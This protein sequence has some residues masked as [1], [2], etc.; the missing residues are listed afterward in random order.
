MRTLY[1]RAQPSI[2]GYG[3]LHG[4]HL[5]D[6]LRASSDDFLLGY[7]V[8]D[9]P[10][11]TRYQGDLEN[12]LIPR[13]LV[14]QLAPDLIIVE[15][16]LFGPI[17]GFQSKLAADIIA[18]IDVEPV[19]VIAGTPKDQLM[20]YRDDYQGIWEFLGARAVYERDWPVYG[21]QRSPYDSH[22]SALLLCK[23]SEMYTS[24]WLLPVFDEIETVGVDGPVVI[25]PNTDG[26]ATSGNNTGTLAG[27]LWVDMSDNF[28]WGSVDVRREAT[29]C[30]LTGEVEGDRML[31]WVPENTRWLTQLC[32][33]L[34]DSRRNE[35]ARI[36]SHLRSPHTVFLAHRSIDKPRVRNIAR[37]LRGCGIAAWLDEDEI[38]LGDS[39]SSAISSALERASCFVLCWSEHCVGAPWV[40]RELHTSV[41]ALIEGRMPIIVIRLD[42]TPVPR[43]ISDLRRL[44]AMDLQPQEIASSLAD[45]LRTLKSRPNG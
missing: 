38:E 24:Q 4:R 27:D 45:A 2:F 17:Q 21:V 13:D 28:T 43:I 31:E 41:H 5:C 20:R 30:W 33:F 22:L 15:A 44:D 29:V 26:V 36:R 23:P 6:A 39:I 19:V 35:R 42:E 8:T 25:R 40:E 1:L 11:G 9:D 7:C 14:R 3:S 37:S 32:T 18:N 12:D 34:V 16:G 10:P